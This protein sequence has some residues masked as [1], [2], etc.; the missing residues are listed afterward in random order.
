MVKPFISV[1]VIAYNRREFIKDAL[2]SIINSMA[3]EDNYELIV[4][5]NFKDK[6]ADCLVRKLS[7]K[8]ILADI[9]SI[10]AKVA[11]G[12]RMANGDVITFLEDDDMYVPER[13]K[14]IEKTFK[15][16][17]SLIYYH[18]NVV[19]IDESCKLVCD[20][21]VEKTNIF[22]S[23]VASA[24]EDKLKVFKRYGWR[25][26]LRLSSMAVR[27]DFAMKWASIIR[28]FPDL[29]DVLLFMLALAEEGTILHD[30]RRLTYYRVSGTSASSVRAVKNPT[31]RFVKAVKN[32]ARHALAR[33]ML[34]AL[35]NR[36]GL[37]EYVGYDE[38]TIIGGIYGG[39]G[40]YLAKAAVNLLDGTTITRLA[41]IILGLT[42]LLSPYLAKRLIYLYY[43]KVFDVWGSEY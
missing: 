37:G 3:I 30:P 14:I 2:K 4:I 22:E 12:A 17:P 15:A 21:L 38:A 19:T 42:Y 11:L 6:Y 8:S 25:L 10:G 26:G 5:K 34:V 41:S 18:N 16:N 31:V 27:K 36:I 13:L 40:K 24:H 20:K 43:T 23:V 39:W 1:I 32:A 35:A 28:L 33:H 29:V 7:G 9:A